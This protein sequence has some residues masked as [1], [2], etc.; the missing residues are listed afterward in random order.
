MSMSLIESLLIMIKESD[1]SEL[2]QVE[3][4]SFPPEFRLGQLI[5]II[6]H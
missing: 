4:L 2:Q 1:S 6:W 5:R 3:Q